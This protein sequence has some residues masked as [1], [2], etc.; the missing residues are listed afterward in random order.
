M[1]SALGLLTAAPDKFVVRWPEEPQVFRGDPAALRALLDIED[2]DRLISDQGLAASSVTM[3]K[4]N[5]MAS[6]ASFSVADLAAFPGAA[7]GID[8]RKV[9]ERLREGHTLLLMGLHRCWPPLMRFGRLL[10]AELG[11]PLYAHAFLTPPGNQGFAHHWDTEAVF[12]AQ[13]AGSKVW[14]LYPPVL[15]D[16]LPR[17]RWGSVPVT[18]G[19]RASF[20]NGE[21]YLRTRLEPGDVLWLPRGWIHN[22]YAQEGASLHISIGVLQFTRHWILEQLLDLAAGDPRFRTAL[23][24]GLNGRQLHEE[25]GELTEHFSR[26]LESL[27]GDRVA[28]MLRVKQ[29]RSQPG[30]RRPAVSSALLEVD[31]DCVAYVPGSVLGAAKK[32]DGIVLHLGD[33]DLPVDGSVARAVGEL[34]SAPDARLRLDDLAVDRDQARELL[35]ELIREGVATPA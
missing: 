30:P 21:P 20:E 22:G 17:H 10:A 8:A 2:I 9:G 33:H 29:L 27:D 15:E 16:P 12:I 1:E 32:G 28:T 35:R 24:P 19:Q 23:P 7:G 3:T 11:H 31:A 4:D 14:E 18:P 25:V 34:I 13:T 5:V 26:W 6:P